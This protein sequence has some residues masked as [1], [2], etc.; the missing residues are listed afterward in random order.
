MQAFPGDIV[1]KTAPVHNA[2]ADS[3]KGLGLMKNPRKYLYN[4][5]FT[6]VFWLRR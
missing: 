4:N 5:S 2:N 3:T 1:H 6:G